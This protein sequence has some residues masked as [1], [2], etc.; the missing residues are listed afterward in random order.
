ML[1]GELAGQLALSGPSFRGSVSAFTRSRK[2][3]AEPLK[4]PF[5]LNAIGGALL[6]TH[7]TRIFP[8]A[9][10]HIAEAIP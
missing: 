7:P 3:S 10:R 4:E 1:R 2:P 5:L 8:L 6:S 9:K